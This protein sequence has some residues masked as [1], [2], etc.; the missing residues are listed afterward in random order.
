MAVVVVA[1]VLV[2]VFVART[3]G[4]FVSVGVFAVLVIVVVVFVT[5][6]MRV[7]RPV[8]VAVFVRVFPLVHGSDSPRPARLAVDARAQQFEPAVETYSRAARNLDHRY[9][10]IDGLD[11]AQR[12]GAVEADRAGDVGLR[13]AGLRVTC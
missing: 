1:G 2:R 10:R 12:G 8:G 13:H 5:V 4:V 11:A 3:V 7:L 6:G 9:A